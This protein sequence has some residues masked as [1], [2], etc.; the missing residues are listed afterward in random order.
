MRRES[1]RDNHE[2]E[3]RREEGGREEGG[4]EG[5]RYSMMIEKVKHVM[6]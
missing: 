3:R 2:G 4:R 1:G 5:D 6:A